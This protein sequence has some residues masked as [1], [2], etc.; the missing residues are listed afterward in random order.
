MKLWVTRA[1]VVV[2]SREP[3]TCQVTATGNRNRHETAWCVRV[4][5]GGAMGNLRLDRLR[6]ATKR[7]VA[8]AKAAASARKRSKR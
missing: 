4:G 1:G 5:T 8:D 3:F 7:E 2:E 6:P